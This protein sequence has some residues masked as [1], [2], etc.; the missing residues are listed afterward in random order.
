[1]L[2]DV[3]I[4]GE[5]SNGQEAL[6]LVSALAPDAVVL[7]LDMPVMRG[8]AAI[9][10]LRELA[11]SM[12]IL[13]Y[14]GVDDATLD[15]FDEAARPDALVRKGAAM[16]ELV[17]AL[18]ALLETGPHD[19]LRIVLGEIALARAVTAFDTWVGLHV[20]ILET[21][22]RGDTLRPEQLGGATLDELQALMGIYAHLSDN[23]QRAAREKAEHVEPI[24]HV[25]RSNGAAA[26]RALCAF[27]PVRLRE[28]Y[29][30]W[31]YAAPADAVTALGELHQHLTDALPV[32]SG[33][34]TTS[35]GQQV[36]GARSAPSPEPGTPSDR[37][38]AATDRAAAA[39]DRAAAAQH[40]AAASIDGLT[41][42]YLRG[43]GHIELER[44]IA[45]ARRTQQ[46]LIL[47]FLD[48]DGL[49]AVNDTHGHNAGDQSLRGVTAALRQ[50]LRDY[51]VIVRHG[52]D[53]FLC[54][55]PGIDIDT[56][57]ARVR[58][59]QATLADDPDGC[60]VTAGL[61]VLNDEDSL[62]TLINRADAE[63][64]E[65]R[66][67]RPEQLATTEPA[68]PDHPAR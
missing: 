55:L 27:D 21:L 14:T 23:L 54:A 28:F 33:D 63:M 53:E 40:R 29:S 9:P 18:Q 56:A 45:R 2:D 4:V 44:E 12:R 68:A 11:P 8:D 24:I 26:R 61:A 50:Q 38:E 3:E 49:K 42:A 16:S 34:A 36:A 37:A 5:A 20:R 10:K 7:D 6:I 65:H 46:P 19:V 1:M 41:G 30:A 60:S 35:N 47:A 67:S 31:N 25:L 17:D 57:R 39:I 66:T 51:D 62:Q 15:A 52:G 22:A 13:L 43:P 48:V 58:R 59:A 32:S 64:Y